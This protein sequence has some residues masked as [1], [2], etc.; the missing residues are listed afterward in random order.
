MKPFH[1]RWLR[2]GEMPLNELPVRVN[3]IAFR[4]YS[5]NPDLSDEEFRRVLGNTLFGAKESRA[6][7]DALFLN[8]CCFE[9]ANWFIP[10]ALLAGPAA[11]KPEQFEKAREKLPRLRQISARYEN[12]T[13]ASEKE[14]H[15]IATWITERWKTAR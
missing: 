4:E 5:R 2:E 11:V 15:K 3:R 6:I 1:L 9:G 13:N 7:D 8:R 12:A 14:L 10:P